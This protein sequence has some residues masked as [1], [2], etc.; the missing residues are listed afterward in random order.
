MADS[1]S[2][3]KRSWNLSQIKGKDTSIEVQVRKYLFNQG[4]DTVRMSSHFP[5]NRTLLCQSTKL[6]S[7]CTGASGT[8]IRDEKRHLCL[9][10]G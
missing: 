2:P 10:A 7:L 5:E 8:D 1:L 4:F 3:E 6:L 9:R